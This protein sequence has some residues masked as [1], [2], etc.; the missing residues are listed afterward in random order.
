MTAQSGNLIIN[1]L[2]PNPKESPEK[3]YEY[4]ELFN[5]GNEIDLTG[6][7]LEDK[8]KSFLL[9]GIMNTNGYAVFYDTVSLNNDNDDIKLVNPNG[10]I[11]SEVV[12]GKASENYSYSL[13]GYEWK[14]TSFLTPGEE[15]KFE[16]I[17]EYSHNIYINELLPDPK[18]SPEKDNEYI[19][20]YNF[21]E[22]I[23]LAGWKLT[24]KAGDYPL[25]GYIDADNYKVF[26]STVSLNND[27]DEIK[28]FDP[29]GEIVSSVIYGKAKENYSYSFKDK[30]W[31]WTSILTPGAG[32]K[33]DEPIKYSHDIYISELLPDPEESPEKDNEYVELY[34]F[35]DEIDLTGWKLQDKTGSFLLEGSIG[36][37][38]YT[39]YYDTISL[40]NSGDE[41]S[42]IDPNGE[43]VSEVTYGKASEG[44]S[45]S[46]KDKEWKWTS[47]PT[48]GEKNKFDEEKEYSQKIKINEIFPNPEEEAE[49][50]IELYNSGEEDENLENWMIKD[51]TKKYYVF[52]EDSI[53]KSEDYLTIYR[54]DFKFALNN[55]GEEI[56]Y[57]YDPNGQKIS[58]VSYSG[59]QK[60]YSYGLDGKKWRWSRYQTPGKINRFEKIVGTKVKIDK[61]IYEDIYADFQI[62]TDQPKKIKK[63][64]WNFGDGHKSYKLEAR[65]KYEKKGKFKVELKYFNGS[66]EIKK[67]YTIEVKK[68]PH[69]EMKIRAL[70]PNPEGKDSQNE[71][72]L[73]KNASD[74]EVNLKNWSIATGWEKLYNHPIREDFEIKRGKTKILT[75]AESSFTLNNEK[76]KIELRYPDG[77]TAYEMKYDKKDKKV[78][79]GE[80]YEK[81]D[82]GW[83]WVLAKSNTEILRNNTKIVPKNTETLQND[84]QTSAGDI[85]MT[86]YLNGRSQVMIAGLAEKEDLSYGLNLKINK[87]LTNVKGGIIL[88]A[89]DVQED[90]QNYYFT[91]NY[92]QNNISLFLKINAIFNRLV[93]RLVL[94]TS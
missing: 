94:Q 46:F 72:I 80:V 52:P 27:G 54:E 15:N 48:P 63:V 65:H 56:V 28:L 8:T 37:D 58:E 13:D 10:Q 44:Y 47:I 2:L 35:G 51:K 75:R 7:K 14:W 12:Y 34:N 11:V 6:W 90:N 31:E 88:G 55:S 57:L 73:I 67:K 69:P 62:L 59:S 41:I 45:Y 53:I 5:K 78:A 9:E 87:N 42:L 92:N 77:E 81:I 84:A 30:E 21:G 17:K 89:A 25:S 66:E 74:D 19:E 71:W 86:P 4:I 26:Y 29:N 85:D 50:Y 23:D 36:N 40:N 39:A 49:E 32:N 18:E 83:Q 93:N 60:G 91:Q 70:S 43:K 22:S 76:A 61:K 1:E 68:L 82:G 64:V 3:D 38:K 16:E 33:F 24:D 79:E 20:L